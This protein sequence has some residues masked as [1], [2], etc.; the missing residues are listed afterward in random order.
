[1][2]RSYVIMLE[3]M[4]TKIIAKLQARGC[5]PPPRE[6]KLDD[7][8]DGLYMNSSWANP[9]ALKSQFQGLPVIRHE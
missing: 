4:K 8:D 2:T 6:P 9:K 7:N 5:D 1:M 3:R